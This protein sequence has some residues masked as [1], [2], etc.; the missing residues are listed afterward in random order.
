MTA[1]TI[2]VITSY[3]PR[4]AKRVRADGVVEGYDSAKHYD[5][6]SEPLTGMGDLLQLLGKLLSRPCCAVVRGAIAD[7]ARTQHVRRLVHT[8]PETG[9]LPTLRDVPRRWLAL[10]L[11]GVPLP[12]GIDRTDLLACA[13]A[14]LPML[15]QP[16]QQA[17][18]V[19]QATG[20]HGLKPGA[21]LRL[22]GWCDRPLSGA[23]GQRWFRGLPVDASLFRPAQVNYTAAPVFAD[24]AQDPLD[25]RL[26]WLRGE[27]RYIAAPSASELAPPPK[28]P[29]DQYRAA[30]VTSTGNGSRYAMAALAKACSLIRQQSE[31]T[32][33]PTAVAEA[34]GLARLVR[35]KLLTKDE[36]VRAIGLALLDVGKPEAEGKAIAE[37]AIAQ[38][39]D[40]GTLPAGVSA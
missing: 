5:L 27:H 10:D 32:R 28:P 11:D 6:H 29:V 23:E 38:R 20:S 7:P 22:W 34:W 35:A 36:V 12:E 33:H 30:A 25:G 37:W 2:T 21:R 26:A 15:P 17:D 14:V 19:V 24:G 1:D 4:L 9:E 39:T 18:L 3:G 13:A 8:D 40:T 31:G 16:L